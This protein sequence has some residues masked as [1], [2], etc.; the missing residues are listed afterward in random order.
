MVRLSSRAL[1][2]WLVLFGL[3]AATTG[4]RAFDHSAYA[5]DE[6]RFLL[7][8]RSLAHDGDVNVFDDYRSNAYRSFYKHPLAGGGAPD[9]V[10]RT[11]YEPGGIGFPLLLTPAY[12]VGGATPVDFF[13][14]A[15]AALAV[16]LAYMLALRVVPDPWAL[17]A[18][19]AVGV[20][21]PLLAYSTTV[22]P[23]LAAG[24]LL[25]G[26]ALLGLEAADRPARPRVFG[27]FLLVALVPWVSVRLVPAALALALYVVVQL[28]RRRH[29]L[30][31]LMGAEIAG[32]SGAL[33]VAL[34]EAVYGGVTPY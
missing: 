2:V 20:S 19:V 34:N 16:A 1:V 23:E 14:A 6:P 22:Y 25:A 12:M 33:F 29:G 15:L 11:Q 3:Y 18:T 24:A 27:C 13:L 28:R 17:G 21:P 10:A 26:A 32:F 30:L 9:R 5:G 8:T 4:M 31:A 7:T